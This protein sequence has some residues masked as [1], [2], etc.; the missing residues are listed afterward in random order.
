MLFLDKQSAANGEQSSTC[1]V[2][3]L[4][5]NKFTIN[6][7]LDLAVSK[8]S[9]E[10]AQ[11]YHAFSLAIRVIVLS[12]GGCLIKFLRYNTN[13]FQKR[14]LGDYHLMNYCS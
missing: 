12:G 4:V 2:R 10:C 3:F 7:R 14:E 9:H 1:D 6:S 13:V 8:S 5:R 11:E